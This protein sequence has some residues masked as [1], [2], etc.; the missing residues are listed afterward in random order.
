MNE[1]QSVYALALSYVEGLGKEQ[2][3]AIAEKCSSPEEIFQGDPTDYIHSIGMS[4]RFPSDRENLQ[5]LLAKASADIKRYESKRV[6]LLSIFDDD[7]PVRLREI[8]D[9]PPLIFVLGSTDFE[10]L[11]IASIVGTRKPTPYGLNFCKSI[12]DE[13]SK[14]FYDLNIV[15]GLAY[16]IDCA[17][18]KSALEVGKKTTAVVAHGLDM[19]YPAAHRDLAMDIINKGGTILSE[20]PFGEKPFRQHFLERNRIIAGLSDVTIVVESAI[21]GGAMSTAHTAF[22]YSREVMALP[23]RINDPQ[24]E[25]CNLLIR[26]EK[27]RLITC[28]ADLI[29]ATGWQPENIVLDSRQRNLFPELSG[30]GKI[31]Y[32]AIRFSN[33]QPVQIDKLMQ[34]TRLP[35]SR[36]MAQLSELEFEGVLLKHPGNRYSTT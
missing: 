7:Y 20:Y 32:D 31:I 36:L 16:G 17:A 23:G 10:S 29:E 27:A 5:A 18:H 1:S 28:A 14:Y 3:K 13:L 4:G 35:M 30:D 19:I 33:E 6:N 2:I 9:A 24:S 11:H 22:S 15:S 8:P 26:K 21:K 34:L 12:V 25:G